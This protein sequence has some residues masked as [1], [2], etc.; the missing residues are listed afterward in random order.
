[1]KTSKEQ[2]G[3]WFDRGQKIGFSYMFIVCDMFDWEDFPTYSDS[4]KESQEKYKKYSESRGEMMK[5]ME[6]YDLRENKEDQLNK[7]ICMAEIK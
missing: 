1:M 4:L 2:I 7:A 3:K 6:V 5:L